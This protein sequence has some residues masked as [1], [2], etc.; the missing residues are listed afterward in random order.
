MCRIVFQDLSS[1]GTDRLDYIRQVDEFSHHLHVSVLCDA[2]VASDGVLLDLAKL[3]LG[4]H[5]ATKLA[6]S[7]S[8]HPTIP[9]GESRTSCHGNHPHGRQC[10]G[11][12][13][14]PR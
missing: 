10:D 2:Q 9:H 3:Q 12:S 1:I 5:P 7:P 11:A 14:V 6:S 8:R 13:T 4:R